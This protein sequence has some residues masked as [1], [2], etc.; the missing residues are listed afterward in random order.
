MHTAYQIF[1]QND[2]C[3]FWK[4]SNNK[5]MLF[6]TIS[7]PILIQFFLF[8]RFYMKI[9]FQTS[10]VAYLKQYSV[11]KGNNSIFWLAKYFSWKCFHIKMSFCG[12]SVKILL[13]REKI[14]ICYILHH[15]MNDKAFQILFFRSYSAQIM[16]QI[17]SAKCS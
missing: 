11:T 15:L 13:W 4:M 3:H 10:I 1:R 5:M 9:L 7:G 16:W 8:V 2:W 14:A 17:F 12:I 6:L